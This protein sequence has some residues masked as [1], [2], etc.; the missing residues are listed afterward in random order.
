LHFNLS[1]ASK[2]RRKISFAKHGTLPF[3]TTSKFGAEMLNKKEDQ[4]ID[5]KI[6]QINSTKAQLPIPSDDGDETFNCS[7]IKGISLWICQYV[8]LRLS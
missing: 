7:S 2:S 4:L 8:V 5:A 6:L 3:F 1:E